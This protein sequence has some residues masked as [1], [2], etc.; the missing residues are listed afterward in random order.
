VWT[1][2]LLLAFIAPLAA[3]QHGDCKGPGAPSL[4]VIVLDPTGQR[5]C[6]ATVQANDGTTTQDFT[7]TATTGNCEYIGIWDRSGTFTITATAHA[8]SGRAENVKV[9]AIDSCNP[10][11]IPHL[12]IT[13]DS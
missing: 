13:L 5:A 1:S 6:D 8:L 9:K 4:S 2:A 11:P 7:S 3:C 10:T 12:T